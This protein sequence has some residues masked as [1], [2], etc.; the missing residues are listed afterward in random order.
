MKFFFAICCVLI[1]F[2][3]PIFAV[4]YGVDVALTSPKIVN[5]ESGKIINASFTVENKMASPVDFTDRLALPSGWQMI[6]TVEPVFTVSAGAKFLRL[7]TF[8]VPSSASSGKY[9]IEYRVEG[10]LEPQISD[11]DT[12][13]VNVMPRLK[14]DLTVEEKPEMVIAG[15]SYE[16][17]LRFVNNSNSNVKVKISAKSIPYYPVKIEPA[18][19]E[20]PAGKYA[21]IKT[22]ISTDKKSIEKIDNLVE[23]K[24]VVEDPG[25]KTITVQTSAATTV[26]PRMSGRVDPYHKMPVQIK[27]ANVGKNAA[28]TIQRII[29]GA[30]PLKE[31]DSK[32][33]AFM[34]RSPDTQDYGAFGQRDEMY[35]SMYDKYV[36]LHYGDRTCELSPLMLRSRFG[37]VCETRLYPGDFNIDIFNLAE[38]WTIQP[39]RLWGSSF[40]YDFTGTFRVKANVL[41]RIKD[42]GGGN[43]AYDD[44][45]A[46]LETFI[47]PNRNTKLAVEFAANK[48][49]RSN[50]LVR[51]TAYRIKME[52]ALFKNTSYYFEKVYARP[53]FWG[54]YRDI[55]Y[56]TGTLTNRINKRLDANLYF[57]ATQY[58]LNFNKAYFSATNEQDYK[59]TLNY[60]FP[61]GTNVSCAYE[62]YRSK[63]CLFPPQSDFMAKALY[64]GIGQ[65]FK[66]ISIQANFGN[67]FYNDRLLNYPQDLYSTAIF[68]NY[69][70]NDKISFSGY[71]RNGY[72]TF[73][74]SMPTKTKTIGAQ[75]QWYVLPSL[76]LN[77][78]TERLSYDTRLGT[79]TLIT[80]LS[81][82]FRNGSTLN[83]KND[84]FRNKEAQT[85]DAYYLLTFSMPIDV[86]LNK[87]K[88]IGVLKGR[89][90]DS[91]KKG[92]PP[93]VNAMLR[94]GGAVAVTDK[95]GGYMFPA[96]KPGNQFLMIDRG[97]IGFNKTTLDK[98][99][100]EVEI[101]GGQTTSRDV[102]ITD[103]C[104]ISGRVL[105]YAKLQDGGSA[106]KPK[107][108]RGLYI[109]GSGEDK[110]TE[111]QG[112]SG[113]LIEVSD[114]KDV[115]H[116]LTD[117]K[118]RF[119][120]KGLRPGSWNL[121]AYA[122]TLPEYHYFEQTE[123]ALSVKPGAKEDVTVKVVPRVRQIKMIEEGGVKVQ[124]GVKK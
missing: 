84:W 52:G 17:G 33:F 26:I 29:T 51:D 39:E 64:Y 120:F 65:S 71:A 100:V 60:Y 106:E 99:P 30:G 82:V 109:V 43:Y 31:G 34:T 59:G 58:N 75:A 25:G 111:P 74:T 56:A 90:Y 13:T 117:E 40:K 4:G 46:G 36:D 92:N 18:E 14:G 70:P 94:L 49:Y 6:S 91:Q 11:F 83:L 9:E 1:F 110:N 12:F 72:D 44:Q 66:K 35:V 19:F 50:M 118:G 123:F 61:F 22:V 62:V 108:E 77:A 53:N 5:T 28:N 78:S 85:D 113:V 121:I 97:T 27:L 96:V 67:G 54:D 16:I 41:H 37:R 63:D 103:T 101:K 104:E 21:F 48:S 55:S 87:K 122:E 107:E 88:S 119:S 114:G 73:T 81:Y 89:V 32:V 124:K 10:K 2:I 80:N 105:V 76:S 102:A 8:F 93:V 3:T 68:V 69:N 116:Q 38:R 45:L 23:F 115:I 57:R 79:E 86:A 98:M 95:N 24:A 20:L 47:A 112:L 42:M 7:V 15:D